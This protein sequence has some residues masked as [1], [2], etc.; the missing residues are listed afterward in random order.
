MIVPWF[1]YLLLWV[2]PRYT[3]IHSI[4]YCLTLLLTGFAEPLEFVQIWITDHTLSFFK[5]DF[6]AERSVVR[7]KI[8]KM[9]STRL[10]KFISLQISQKVTIFL[11]LHW[12]FF[13]LGFCTIFVLY[14]RLSQVFIQSSIQTADLKA[15]EVLKLVANISYQNTGSRAE[16]VVSWHPGWEGV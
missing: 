14:Q 3:T 8:F 2:P 16:I 15:E 12:I 7:W 9:Q 1:I 13:V 6:I 5:A 4:N 11:E 10:L